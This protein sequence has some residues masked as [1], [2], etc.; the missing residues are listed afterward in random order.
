MSKIFAFLAGAAIGAAVM[1]VYYQTAYDRTLTEIEAEP[2]RAEDYK[3]YTPN[4]PK[5]DKPVTNNGPYR[6][7]GQDFSEKSDYT[8]GTLFYYSNGILTD[9]DNKVIDIHCDI[10]D[11]LT[12]KEIETGL[13]DGCGDTLYLRDDKERID[14]EVLMVDDAFEDEEGT[15]GT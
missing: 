6:I 5:D 12:S 8:T 11:L 1:A 14:Y 2:D 7:D 9:S 13:I 15:V 10:K 4:E 3:T